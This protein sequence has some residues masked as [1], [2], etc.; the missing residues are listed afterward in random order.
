M[1]Y[2][3]I[4]LTAL[5]GFLAGTFKSSDDQIDALKQELE[6]ATYLKG[7]AQTSANYYYGLSMQIAKQLEECSKP[8]IQTL[9]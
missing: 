3:I 5:S 7:L 6:S 4:I 9:N 8:S 2:I 1:K